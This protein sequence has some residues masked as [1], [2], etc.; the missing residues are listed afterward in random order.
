MKKYIFLILTLFIFTTIDAQFGQRRNRSSIPQTN[1]Q[2]PKIPDFNAEKAVG[3]VIY[4]VEKTIKKI[5]LKKSSEKGKKVTS[6]FNTLN[7]EMK[8]I[9]RI[10]SFTFSEAK[11]KMKFAQQK[12]QDSGDYS[13]L[14]TVYTEVGKSF[15]PILATLKE[16]EAAFDKSLKPILSE[17]QFK[18]WEK[19]RLKAKKAK[20]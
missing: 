2:K 8:Q 15:E 17:K 4:D 12:A 16:K 20:R 18:K 13:T 1:N 6:L 14:K 9:S 11:R 10:N 7:K 5:G 19:Y 3:L